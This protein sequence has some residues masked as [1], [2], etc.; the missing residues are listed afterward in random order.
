MPD[1]GPEGRRGAGSGG[2]GN[3][4]PADE[5]TG[6]RLMAVAR[7]RGFVWPSFEIY[8]GSAG[9]WDYG[10]QGS[11]MMHNL[12][13]LWRRV[14]QVREG[15]LE[16]NCPVVTPGVVFEA[17]GHVEEFTDFKV[18]CAGCGGNFRADH[19]V[20]E[21]HPNPDEL[22]LDELADLLASAGVKC[23]ACGGALSPPT[24]YNLMFETRLGPG[25]RKP[26]YLRPETAQGIFVNFREMYRQNR[27]S[28]PFGVVQL[29]RG[30][31][32]EISPRQGMIRLREFRMAEMEYFVHPDEP[33]HPE[34][35]YVSALTLPLVDRDGMEKESTVGAAV[36]DGTIGNKATAY[37]MAR[38]CEFL[39]AAGVDPEKLRFRQHTSQEMAHYANDCWDA[40]V[41]LGI[42]WTEVVGIADRS[43]FDL[44]RHSEHTTTDLRAVRRFDEPVRSEVRKV[45]PD[46]K[47]LGPLF[48][49]EAGKVKAALEELAEA[50]V[51]ALAA[52][53]A[54]VKVDIA[55]DDGAT[56]Q[57]EVPADAYEVVTRTVVESGESYLPRVIEPSFGL[58]RIFYTVMEHSYREYPVEGEGGGDDG[59]GGEESDGE[60]AVYRVMALP[61]SIAPVACGVFPLVKKEPLVDKAKAIARALKDRGLSAYYDAGGTIG[62]RYARMDEIGTPYCVTVDFDSLETG[63]VTV[64]NRDTCEQALV[65][66]EGLD[67]VIEELIRGRTQAVSQAIQRAS[68]QGRSQ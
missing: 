4:L 45:S 20:E 5:G 43:C 48:K 40:E 35:D 36:A 33:V 11:A 46:M 47:A 53:P 67:W 8:G 13:E 32:N 17:S 50:E 30:Y 21:H 1:D 64:R 14:F 2:R 39:L 6:K 26:A 7:R 65:D 22:S 19:L 28:I 59:S 63:K 68:S 23:P 60:A 66:I 56:R 41:L 29:G 58:D 49:G 51:E 62:R 61:P 16:V 37:W 38:T 15:A 34:F 10:P 3:P 12:E 27:E 25:S 24:T 31:R 55:G 18:E 57:V 52:G 9:L 54:A 42:G 44:S